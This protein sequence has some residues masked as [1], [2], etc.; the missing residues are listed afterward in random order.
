MTAIRRAASQLTSL[1]HRRGRPCELGKRRPSHLYGNT[2]SVATLGRADAAARSRGLVASGDEL[3][4]QL[5]VSPRAH[6][7]KSAVATY[8]QQ[9]IG[10][11]V[12][13]KDI[14]TARATQILDA[15]GIVGIYKC[16]Q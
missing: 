15:L 4:I 16:P 5:T 13:T 6:L 7:L 8:H 1:R 11:I 12:G 9:S 14:G 3:T 10:W 2:S